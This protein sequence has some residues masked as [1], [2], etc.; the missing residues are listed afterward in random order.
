MSESDD[1]RDELSRDLRDLGRALAGLLHALAP[2]AVIV[3]VALVVL[4]SYRWVKP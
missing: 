4:L 2:V 3:A 1:A